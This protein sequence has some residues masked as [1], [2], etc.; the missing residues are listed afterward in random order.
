MFER[1]LNDFS[2]RSNKKLLRDYFNSI[3]G[4]NF[5]TIIPIRGYY[6]NADSDEVY[7]TLLNKYNQEVKN[8]QREKRKVSTVTARKANQNKEKVMLELIN[9]RRKS[10]GVPVFKTL[11]KFAKKIDIKQKQLPLFVNELQNIVSFKVDEDILGKLEEFYT[12]NAGKMIHIVYVID[13]Q[14]IRADERGLRNPPDWN[15]D[16]WFWFINTDQGTVF[17]YKEFQGMVYAYYPTEIIS[18]ERIA[19]AYLDGNVHCVLD[20]IRNWVLNRLET[21]TNLNYYKAILNKLD[22]KILKTGIKKIGLIEKFKDGVPDDQ[23]ENISKELGVKIYVKHL[24]G[25]EICYGKDLIEVKTFHYTNSR[26]NHLD[27][28]CYDFYNKD[29]ELVSQLEINEIV[30]EFID[31]KTDFVFIKMKGEIFIVHTPISSGNKSYKVK[32]EYCE[33]VD[34]FETETVI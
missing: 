29:F 15:A 9:T 30:E 18:K 24:F 12:E 20:P 1:R 4:T 25:D 7:E 34:Q 2:K 11:N 5:K 8:K 10:N 28:G 33:V 27:L 21:K 23:M 13:E 3:T 22:G 31:T 19:Q 16:Q 17:R 26:V 32:E 14:I 6:L